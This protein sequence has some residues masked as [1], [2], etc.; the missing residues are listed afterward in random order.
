MMK[1][2]HLIVWLACIGQVCDGKPALLYTF[3][4]GGTSEGREKNDL[5]LTGECESL[6][7]SGSC[8]PAEKI[9]DGEMETTDGRGLPAGNERFSLGMWVNIDTF[10]NESKPLATLGPIGP[11]QLI[12]GVH[13]N[14]ALYINTTTETLTTSILQNATWYFFVAKYDGPPLDTLTIYQD[15]TDVYSAAV[16]LNFPAFNS[17]SFLKGGGAGWVISMDTISLEPHLEVPPQDVA[18]CSFDTFTETATIT[19]PI[20]RTKTFSESSTVTLSIPTPTETLNTMTRTGTGTTTNSHTFSMSE[21]ATLNTTPT[22]TV[23][24]TET[25]SLL[26]HVSFILEYSAAPFLVDVLALIG[27]VIA[28]VAGTSVT[29]WLFGKFL[30]ITVSCSED[31]QSLPFFLNP[32]GV[33]IHDS[34]LIGTLT[35]LFGVLFAVSLLSFSASSCFLLRTNF[36]SNLLRRQVTG[37][38]PSQL[39]TVYIWIYPSCA[40]V[41]FRILAGSTDAWMVVAGLGGMFLSI[42]PPISCVLRVRENL[43]LKK[44]RYRVVAPPREGVYVSL[45]GQGEWVSMAEDDEKWHGAHRYHPLVRAF[46]PNKAGLA[47]GFEFFTLFVLSAVVSLR[48]YDSAHCA[49][50]K[51]GSAG[52]LAL[53]ALFIFLAKP[54][55]RVKD[56]AFSSGMLLMGS[57]SCVLMALDETMTAGRW[58]VTSCLIIIVLWGL[59]DVGCYIALI[60]DGS[61]SSLQELEWEPS[62]QPENV[63]YSSRSEGDGTGDRSQSSLS[64]PMLPIKTGSEPSPVLPVTTQSLNLYG[65]QTSFLGIARKNT[66]MSRTTSN[67]ESLAPSSPYRMGCGVSTNSF[68]FPTPRATLPRVASNSIFMNG[69]MKT[70]RSDLL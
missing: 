57:V 34:D 12:I 19:E 59:V 10:G 9:G 22:V 44:M 60:F 31:L 23:T 26:P 64:F 52:V 46:T 27:F 53:S 13:D 14:G 67:L 47:I 25:D 1:L 33:K 36:G 18:T 39:I 43:A 29:P 69:T 50:I 55:C 24:R 17:L 7:V 56:W 40:T 66:S 8:N 20:T 51:Y 6:G 38:F 2:C 5:V 42:Y 65:G 32:F 54:F 35:C 45:H 37:I 61:R 3:E 62:E 63:L 48:Y 16:P 58:V 21:T 68:M 28:I 11:S 49:Y 30:L 41:F 4:Q 70:H 15:Y